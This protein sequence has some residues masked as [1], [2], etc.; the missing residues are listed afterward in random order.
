MID[1]KCPRVSLACGYGVCVHLSSSLQSYM[2]LAI[3][4]E[5]LP[6]VILFPKIQ[7]SKFITILLLSISVYLEQSFCWAFF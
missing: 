1:W 2:Y 3:P 6:C 5:N 4:C 7:L